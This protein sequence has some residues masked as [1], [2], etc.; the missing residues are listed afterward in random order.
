MVAV[1]FT[2]LVHDTLDLINVYNICK[3]QFNHLKDKRDFGHKKSRNFKVFRRLLEVYESFSSMDTIFWYIKREF[4]NW[5][6]CTCNFEIQFLKFSISSITSGKDRKWQLTGSIPHNLS[7]TQDL[8]PL[9]ISI[10][11]TLSPSSRTFANKIFYKKNDDQSNFA[12]E[13]KN[14]K[15]KK[16][17]F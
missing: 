10:L 5:Y 3:F 13:S 4:F 1:N 15:F 7:I 6:R 8:S 14:E 9:K 2:K 16:S 17:C 12:N 11:N